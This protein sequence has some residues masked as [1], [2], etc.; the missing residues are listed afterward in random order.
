LIIPTKNNIMRS[1]LVIISVI[2]WTSCGQDNN[3]IKKENDLFETYP[4]RIQ[5]VNFPKNVILNMDIE[6]ELIFDITLDSIYESNLIE[7][8]TYLYVTTEV[9]EKLNAKTI[10]NVEHEAYVDRL[11]IGKFNFKVKFKKNGETSLFLV[12]EDNL[13]IKPKDTNTG[14][15]VRTFEY[16]KELGVLVEE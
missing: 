16:G 14:I 2:I 6:G 10:Q 8:H 4:F 13:L 12:I 5:E 3:K 7:R 15:T 11:G 9:L 1:I